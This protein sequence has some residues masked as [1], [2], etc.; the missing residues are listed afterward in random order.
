M[1][2]RP[3][4][5]SAPMVQALLAGRKTQTRRVVKGDVHGFSLDP[6]RKDAMS[7]GYTWFRANGP[8]LPGNHLVACPYGEP[9]DRLWVKETWGLND[10]R[11]IRP[12]PIP[13]SRPTDMEDDALVY[14]ATESDAEIINE[15]PRTPSIFMPRWASRITL[16]ITDI[17]VERLHD[18]SE[19][20]AMAEGVPPE[21]VPPDGGSTPY[22]EGYRSLWDQING[23]GAWDKNPWL[24]VVSFRRVDSQEQ[25][26]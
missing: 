1:K 16:E 5:F 7:S 10:Y 15:M 21:L 6:R 23:A 13:K 26:A 4:L 24:W 8:D 9:G 3:I 20:D 2:E 11:Y 14:F 22:A 12:N 17:R 25:P 18:I 19:A